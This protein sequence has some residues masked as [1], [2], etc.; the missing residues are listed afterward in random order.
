MKSEY[1]EIIRRLK[2]NDANLTALN[3]RQKDLTPEESQE[4]FKALEENTFV[5]KVQYLGNN[6]SGNAA[7]A[8]S[9]MLEKNQTIE[10]LELGT[11]ELNNEDIIHIVR[12]LK[13]NSS[14]VIIDLNSNLFDTAE[15]IADLLEHNNHIKEIDLTNSNI[16]NAGF[17]EIYEALQRNENSSLTTFNV[18]FP[19]VSC[20]DDFDNFCR[21]NASRLER[22]VKPF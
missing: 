5:T 11:N 6:S 22:G 3:L 13:Q 15:P 17:S 1:E 18:Y 12:G 8:L 21:A 9:V 7:I 2:Q 14:V 4:F 19:Q 10:E 20:I 16:N